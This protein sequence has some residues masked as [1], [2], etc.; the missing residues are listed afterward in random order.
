MRQTLLK[1]PFNLDGRTVAAP[2]DDR[3]VVDFVEQVVLRAFDLGAD[4]LRHP[5]RGR[6]SPARARQV[7]M[8][9][10]HVR[11]GVTLSTCARAFGRDR[12]TAA[13]ACRRVEDMREN[14]RL[15]VRLNS[16]EAAIDRWA[17]LRR[18]RIGDRRRRGG[19]R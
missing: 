2:V 8:Y 10:L 19:A 9:L 16:L 14:H 15:D 1:C 18:P 13:H 17:A 12:T 7:A 11:L 3:A 5:T 6:Q 4:T